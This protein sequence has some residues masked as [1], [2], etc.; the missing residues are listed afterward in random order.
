MQIA[1]IYAMLVLTGCVRVML[2]LMSVVLNG[3]LIALLFVYFAD[4]QLV[5][6]FARMLAEKHWVFS[7]LLLEKNCA[8]INIRAT[9]HS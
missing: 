2:L 6:D 5:G 1:H 8:R 9:S 7:S 3:S 4:N